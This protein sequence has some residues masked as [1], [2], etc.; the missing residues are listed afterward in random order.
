MPDLSVPGACGSVFPDTT[1]ATVLATVAPAPRPDRITQVGRSV[2]ALSGRR[3]LSV[4]DV[5]MKHCRTRYLCG[6]DTE[7]RV[8]G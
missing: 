4:A 3:P 8:R 6:H 7:V 5:H 1:G 2:G